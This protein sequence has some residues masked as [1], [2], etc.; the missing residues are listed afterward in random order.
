MHHLPTIYP[1]EELYMQ[2][3]KMKIL[4]LQS[5]FDPVSRQKQLGLG[6]KIR[7]VPWQE[8]DLYYWI[9]WGG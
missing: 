2:K 6:K 4:L 7:Q 9:K 8:T 5:K 3:V 1:I